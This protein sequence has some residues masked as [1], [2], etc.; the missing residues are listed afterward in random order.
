MR[1]YVYIYIYA[2]FAVYIY[3]G[4]FH[5]DFQGLTTPQV[6]PQG[7][8]ERSEP[9]GMRDLRRILRM[10]E[11]FGITVGD[12]RAT[13]GASAMVYQVGIERPLESTARGRSVEF[14]FRS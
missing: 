3:K 13:C 8:G 14:M 10:V 12:C 4:Q 7:R 6:T 11:T 9:L 2:V 5:V 1:M